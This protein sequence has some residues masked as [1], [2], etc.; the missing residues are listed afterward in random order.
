MSQPSSQPPPPPPPLTAAPPAP[1]RTRTWAE[2]WQDIRT[3]LRNIPRAVRLVWNAHRASTLAL[4]ALTLVSAGLPAAQAW[5]GKLVV[6]AVVNAA[7]AGRDPAASVGAIAPLL[8][9]GFLLVTLGAALN[10]GYILLEHMLN[11]RLSHTINEEIIDKAL[12][13]DLR[14]FEDAAFYDKL[15]NARREADFRALAIVNNLFALL[16]GALVLLSFAGVLLLISP[17]IAL[18]L[19]GATLPTFI[20][21]ARYAGL[22][23]RLLSSR[24]PEFRRMQYIEYLLTVDN[25]V[26]EVKLFGLGRPLFKQYQQ[27]FWQFYHEDAALARRR[28]LLSVG[29]GTLSTASFYAAY[30]WVVW[31]TVAGALTLGD[32]T[33]YL[34]VFQQSQSTFRNL[35][36]GVGRLYE[37]ALFL[38]NLF[39]FLAQEPQMS[40]HAEPRPFPRPLQQGIEFRG[41]SFYYPGAR[42]WAVYNINLTIQAGETVA[43]VGRNGAGKTT[44]IKLLA[45]FYD[46]TE[47]QIFIDG[48]DIRDYAPEDLR[49]AVSVIF[50]DYVQYHAHLRENIGFGQIDALHDEARIGEAAAQ[51]GADTVAAGLPSGY[52]TMLGRWFEGGHELSG[53]QWQK[54]ALARAFMRDAEILVLDE[55]TAALD[56]EHEYDL[57]QRFDT[58]T[59][60]KTA[61]LISHRFSTVRMA[62]RIVVLMEAQVAEVGTHA[63]LLARDGHYAHLFRLQARGYEAAS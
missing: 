38:D 53:G 61:L 7:Q 6:D 21:Q 15:Q 30:A 18:I 40:T 14:Y 45:R 10:Q 23:F 59:Q 5:V 1:N 9:V 55:P 47:G 3:A 52:D 46:P 57:F 50:Q 16:Q 39:T 13:L 32:L 11:A 31:R 43:F 56:A 4:C 35:I 34:V 8:L 51:G 41:V 24:A 28:S 20:V 60:Q 62:D 12:A 27:L 33:L 42:E 44:L 22:S 25:S 2:R 48:V 54:I 26:K 49:R 36:S 29:W 19:F 37:G 17:L 63:E 58:M